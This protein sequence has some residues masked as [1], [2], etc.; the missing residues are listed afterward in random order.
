[1]DTILVVMVG[2]LLSVTTALTFMELHRIRKHL[3]GKGKS[4]ASAAGK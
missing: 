3:E 2:S 1:M 4:Q